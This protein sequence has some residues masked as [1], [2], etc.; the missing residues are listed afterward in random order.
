MIISPHLLC[1]TPIKDRE[2]N[3]GFSGD[4]C[5]HSVS[6]YLIH[7]ILRSLCFFFL[8]SEYYFYPSPRQGANLCSPESKMLCHERILVR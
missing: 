5:L 8:A 1:L 7:M 6:G 3:Q 4:M 2:Q